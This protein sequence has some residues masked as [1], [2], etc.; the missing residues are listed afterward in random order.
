MSFEVVS[1]NKQ[2]RFLDDVEHALDKAKRGYSIIERLLPLV[3]G[4][5]PD[6]ISPLLPE[7]KEKLTENTALV[8][9]ILETIERLKTKYGVSETSE[10]GDHVAAPASNDGEGSLPADETRSD[11]QVEETA[12]PEK[13]VEEV[14]APEKKAEE[15]SVTEKEAEEVVASVMFMKEVT[16]ELE[17]G[18]VVAVD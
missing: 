7:L 10:N 18:E 2:M 1:P 14:V 13:K 11:L 12:V 9:E 16:N 6:D 8:N 4:K 5:L 17:E 3:D 15:A